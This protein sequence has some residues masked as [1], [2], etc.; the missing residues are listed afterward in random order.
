MDTFENATPPQE[1]EELAYALCW[2]C[3]QK[4]LCIEHIV[5]CTGT[6]FYTCE[7]CRK[8]IQDKPS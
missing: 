8:K 5:C 4:K 6:R 1:Q 7:D 2:E 3:G